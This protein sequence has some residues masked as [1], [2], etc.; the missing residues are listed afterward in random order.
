MAWILQAGY[1]AIIAPRQSRRKRDVGSATRTMT[2]VF[3]F[4]RSARRTLQVSATET[5]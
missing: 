3:A 2:E 1:T 5:M 4:F